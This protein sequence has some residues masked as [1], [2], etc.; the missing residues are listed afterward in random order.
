MSDE[1]RCYYFGCIDGP[2]HYLHGPT[3]TDRQRIEYYGGHRHVH[4]DGTLAPR[5]L[6]HGPLIWTGQGATHQER[7]RLAT[8][9]EECPQGQ[10]LRH[11][12]DTGFSAMQWWDRTQGDRRGAC[13]GT[14]L[15]EGKHPTASLLAALAAHYPSVLAN[16]TAARVSL[17][18]VF[19][20]SP[21]HEESR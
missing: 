17:V 20:A 1:P 19:P 2:G 12:L 7:Q 13:N 10:F 14:L 16:L 9:S 4:I 8:N 3:A 18:E 6:R 21:S 11:E 15:L 5:R